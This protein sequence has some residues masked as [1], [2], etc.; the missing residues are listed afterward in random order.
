MM[1]GRTVSRPLVAMLLATALVPVSALAQSE[2][3]AQ[4]S[5]FSDIVV[6]AQKRAEDISDVPLTIQAFS[7]HTLRAAGVTQTADLAMVVP[8][9][10]FSKSSA[11][12]PIFTVRGIG[13]NTPNLSSTSPVGIYVNEVA[14]AYPY[15]ANGP[16]FDIE[17]VEILKGPQ[18]TLYGRNTTGGLVNFITGAPKKDFSAGATVD[19]GSF[20]TYN[21]EGY[22]NLPLGEAAA[23]RIAARSENSDKGWQRSVSRPGDRLGQKD[24]QAARLSLQLDPSSVVR[25]NLTANYWQDKSHTVAPQATSFLP[26]QAA[27]AIPGLSAS[28]L[29]DPDARDADWDSAEAG[30]PPFRT[31]SRFWSL[32]GRAEVDLGDDLTLTS[33]TAYSDLRRRDFN[34]LDGTP[35]ETLAYGSN[36]NIKSFSQELRLNGRSGPVEWIVGSYYSHDDIADDQSAYYGQSST[37]R[38]LRFL[39]A[40]RVV[41]TQYTP[42]QIASGLRQFRNESAQTS[43]SASVFGNADWELSDQFRV[44]AGLRYSSDSLKYRGC[45]RD[46]NGNSLPVW[47]TGVAFV[48]RSNPNVGLNECL[49]FNVAFTDNVPIVEKRLKEDNISGRI[50]LSYTPNS[51]TLIYASVSRGFKSGAFPVLAANSEAQL[52]PARQEKVMAYESGIKAS[53]ADRCVQL[54]ASAFFYDYRNKQLFGEIPD[55]VFTTLTRIL[56]VPK[57]EVYG[58]EADLTFR[59]ARGL[60]VKLGASYTHTE[61]TEYLG[62]D[63]S[64]AV[65]DFS[66]SRFPYTP[67]WQVNGLVNYE[68]PVTDT[69]GVQTTVSAA[70]LSGTRGTIENDS[71]FDVDPYTIVNANIGLYTLDDKWRLSLSARNLFNKYYWTYSDTNVDTAVRIPGMVRT[72]LVTASAK[73]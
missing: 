43:R 48:V 14:Y 7:G 51:D 67:E 25:I 13:F 12:T 29:A 73:F 32:A 64:A 10:N 63:R 15:M 52:N 69:L 53:L 55:R 3:G 20:E 57:S 35:F 36:G 46:A 5:E 72:F 21:F 50:N 39:G 33:L 27:F 68:T 4:D 41:Q 71:R 42:V 23:V 62:F 54:N 11:N 34:D 6:T 66:G 49:T 28:I 26:D 17:R 22:L 19:L 44:S 40:N 24:R 47:N 37:V 16:T 70:Y 45:T 61:I 9:F 56:N 59:P 31:D 18:G 38:L 58:A 1:M 2:V 60:T 30:K 8:G 65:V